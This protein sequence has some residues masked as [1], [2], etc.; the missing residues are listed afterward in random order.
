M[1]PL[2]AFVHVK[3]V[4]T[5]VQS[6][7]PC[8]RLIVTLTVN[9]M[10]LVLRVEGAQETWVQILALLGQLCISSGHSLLIWEMR[11]APNLP[12]GNK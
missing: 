3:T 7:D 2:P 9:K 11:E 8:G 4:L 10:F 6:R 5:C 1:D 12:H